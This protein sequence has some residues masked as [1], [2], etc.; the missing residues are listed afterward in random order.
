MQRGPDEQHAA[1]RAD[2]REGHVVEILPEDIVVG[3]D[4]LEIVDQHPTADGQYG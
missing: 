3:V 1:L 2:H 4:R